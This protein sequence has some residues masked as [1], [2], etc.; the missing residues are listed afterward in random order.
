MITGQA[1]NFEGGM[2]GWTCYDRGTGRAHGNCHTHINYEGR[3]S[4][5]HSHGDCPN[6]QGGISQTFATTA[7]TSYKLIFVAFA[8]TWDGTDTDD[9]YIRVSNSNADEW[10][11]MSVD[12]GAWNKVE[13]AFVADGEVQITIWSD[14]NHCIDVDDIILQDCSGAGIEHIRRVKELY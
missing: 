11:Q 12:H 13:H 1:S 4:V 7:R 6:T 3:S 9:F 2:G 8:G 5:A 10:V 14:V